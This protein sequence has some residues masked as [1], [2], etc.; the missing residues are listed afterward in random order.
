MLGTMV[1]GVMVNSALY[2]LFVFVSGHVTGNRWAWLGA[3]AAAGATYLTY[4]VLVASV[5][6]E[7]GSPVRIMAFALNCIAILLAAAAGFALLF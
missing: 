3:T 2:L 1:N 7:P 6:A 4:L 5:D